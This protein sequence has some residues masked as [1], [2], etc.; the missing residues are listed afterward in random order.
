[1][2]L[3]IKFFNIFVN[4]NNIQC[5]LSIL[6]QNKY[7]NISICKISFL[8]LKTKVV[9]DGYEDYPV[10]VWY[11]YNNN[12]IIIMTKKKLYIIR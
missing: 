9:I 6:K 7:I 4:S 1:M 11:G 8:K 10:S 5:I 3:I 12:S 2:L